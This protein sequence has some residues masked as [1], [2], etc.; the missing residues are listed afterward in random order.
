MIPDSSVQQAQQYTISMF[1]QE[2]SADEAWE[3]V[4]LSLVDLGIGLRP[5]TF[6]SVTAV[7][8]RLFQ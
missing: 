2:K 6:V 5:S 3:M 8:L 7:A 4:R 1:L